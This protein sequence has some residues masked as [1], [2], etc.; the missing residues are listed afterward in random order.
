[1]ETTKGGLDISNPEHIT[2]A[3]SGIEIA[4]LGGIFVSS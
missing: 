4:V 1:M 2:Y 3:H